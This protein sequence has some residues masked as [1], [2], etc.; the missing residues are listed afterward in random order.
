MIQISRKF[1]GGFTLL[2]LSLLGLLAGSITGTA[3]AQIDV[4][5]RPLV[6]DKEVL[7]QLIGRGV[8]LPQINTTQSD[9]EDLNLAP[10]RTNPELESILEKAKRY[11][12]D[13]N[14]RV[15]TQLMQAVLEQ[16]GDTLFSND[17]QI[18][19][20]L[21]RQVEQQLAA[22]PA[23]GLAAYRLEADAE[24]RAIISAGE[25]GNLENALHQVVGRYFVSSVGVMKR[26]C[27]WAVCIWSNT[28][29]SA[30]DG[31]LRRRCSIQTCRLIKIKS[32][33]MSRCAIY[34]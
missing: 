16:S 26:R 8:G 12:D 2:V 14:Y 11:Q 10:L 4:R 27:V 28:T 25:Q 15:A 1:N 9:L 19:Y 24:A 20:S 18:Y 3:D 30:H 34:F 33:R 17:E 5:N 13:G 23:E 29:L 32:G 21:V 6:L 7:Q 31:F 22:L